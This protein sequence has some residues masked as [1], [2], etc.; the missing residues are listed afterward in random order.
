MHCAD[1]VD[2]HAVFDNP[3]VSPTLD[4]FRDTLQIDRPGT[5]VACRDCPAG[6]WYAS[7]D[8]VADLPCLCTAMHRPMWTEQIDERGNAVLLCDARESAIA[9]LMPKSPS[10]QRA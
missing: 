7:G 9:E 1:M 6:I 2:H 10:A 4:Y 3:H 5:E 8:K